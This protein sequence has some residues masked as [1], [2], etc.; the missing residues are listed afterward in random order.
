MGLLQRAGVL[1]AIVSSRCLSNFRD[2]YNLRHL[3]QR[4]YTTTHTFFFSCGELIVTLEDMANQLLLPILG[5]VDPTA[6]E[7]SPEEE[8]I[9]AELRKR[10]ARNAKLSYWVSS[11][12]KFSVAARRAA[13]IA[14][15]LCK[16]VFGSHPHYA[17][18]PLYFHLAIKISV[19]VSLPL[20]PMF[21]E[22]LYIQLDILRSDESQAGSCHIVTSSV[23]CTILQQLFFKHCAQYLT[24]CRSAQFARE[25]YQTCPRM[26]T[27]FYG[28]FESDF[29]LAFRWSGLK[30]I[31]YSVVE[32]FD[33]GVSSS[34]RAYRN[35]GADYTCADSAMGS[36]VDTIE[37]T[38]PLGPLPHWLVLMKQGSPILLLL[39]LDGC[40]TWPMKA[41][42]MF[43]ILPTG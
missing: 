25:K 3:V 4:W 35:L 30:P 13:F 12:S 15:W 20:A 26:I 8:A 11:S 18:M 39:I 14:F 41:L 9:E 32:S 38:T 6:L 23:H 29:P 22:H 24:K 1:K 7:F 31:G 34:W 2:L 5:N 10:M 21:L 36:F 27:D 40:L 19:G 37:T 17:I 28:M 43:T 33:E 16:F 42:D